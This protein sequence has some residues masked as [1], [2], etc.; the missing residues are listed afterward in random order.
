MT[1]TSFICQRLP[2][3]TRRTDRVFRPD[4]RRCLGASDVR[5]AGQPDARDGA[6]RSRQMRQT[7]LSWL[8]GDLT[9]SRL[10]DAGCGTG[11]SRRGRPA[12]RGGGRDRPLGVPGRDRAGAHCPRTS[13]SGTSIL[14]RRRHADPMTWASSITSSRWTR[15]IHYETPESR[16]CA[17]LARLAAN[18]RQ[19]IVFTFAP[20]HVPALRD[21]AHA[22]GRSSFPA[23][24]ARRR[25]CRWRQRTLRQTAWTMRPVSR[26]ERAD[27][28]VPGARPASTSLTRWRSRRRQ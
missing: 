15:L 24:T 18:T 6:R 10:L 19:S 14:P 5:C 3:T 12:W 9:G 28:D 8:P 26:R 1:G 23:P 22:L 27:R 20:R 7:L 13:G 4:G 16:W 25:S 17:V 2:D 11:P 21:H